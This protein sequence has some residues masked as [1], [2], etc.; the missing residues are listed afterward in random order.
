M[1]SATP[2]PRPTACS[3]PASPRLG[4]GT[5][6]GRTVTNRSWVLAAAWTDL[7]NGAS[8]SGRRAG[9]S[10]GHGGLPGRGCVRAE[11]W[12]RLTGRCPYSSTL[13]LGHQRQMTGNRPGL[14]VRVQHVLPHL[15]GRPSDCAPDFESYSTA[16]GLF[17]LEQVIY[18]FDASWVPNLECLLSS[19]HG[20]QCLP[21]TGVITPTL[22][23]WKLRQREGERG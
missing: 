23:M 4:K 13:T 6:E 17:D 19:R 9:S 5:P 21:H 1:T 16:Y 11:V 2:T 15:Q 7:G 18:P 14:S 8:V 3:A 12:P 20:A 22:Q 10:A